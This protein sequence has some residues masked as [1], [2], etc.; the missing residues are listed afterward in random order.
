MPR[1]VKLPN[2][3]SGAQKLN[4]APP[5]SPDRMRLLGALQRKS[6]TIA[7]GR[8][9]GAWEEGVALHARTLELNDSGVE[10]TSIFGTRG[11]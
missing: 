7:P 11:R 1:T 6:M 10:V 2:K 5:E 4:R 8:Q 9:I 3:T